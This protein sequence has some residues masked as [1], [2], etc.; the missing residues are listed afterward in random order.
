MA[1]VVLARIRVDACRQVCARIKGRKPGNGIPK[2]LPGKE[3]GHGTNGI[4]PEVIGALYSFWH[5]A[6]SMDM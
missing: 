2:S 5:Q 6:I 3:K 1:E 4:C